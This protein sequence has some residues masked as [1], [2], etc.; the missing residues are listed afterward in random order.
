MCIKVLS[1]HFQSFTCEKTLDG[2]QITNWYL[3]DKM[4]NALLAYSPQMAWELR[5]T[6]DFFK[7]TL[8]DVIALIHA[9]S[10]YLVLM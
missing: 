1:V 6:P 2:Y 3:V 9:H 8:D 4:L 7:I 10:K 5:R